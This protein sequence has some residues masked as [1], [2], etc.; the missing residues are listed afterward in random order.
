MRRFS[1]GCGFAHETINI[2]KI[3][4]IV[5]QRFSVVHFAVLCLISRAFFAFLW[6]LNNVDLAVTFNVCRRLLALHI[7][8][9]RWQPSIAVILEN[10]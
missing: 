10:F 6:V 2:K 9:S 5:E 1:V 8:F 3:L 4:P 7:C